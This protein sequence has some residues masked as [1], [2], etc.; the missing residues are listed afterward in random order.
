MD[1]G[2]WA[3]SL[4]GGSKFGYTLLSV[5]IISNFMAIFLQHLALKLGIATGRRSRA[6][7][8]RSHYSRPVNFMLWVACEIAIA[9]CDLAEVIGSAIALNL[10]FGIPLFYGV[11]LTALD[12]MMI[13]FLQTRGFRWIEAFVLALIAII[14]GCF[15]RG[16][17]DV[18]TRLE[19]CRGGRH[20]FARHRS[21]SGNAL[22]RHRYSRGDGDAAQSLPPL[23]DC[24]DAPL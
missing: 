16:D 18:A 23:L 14:G 10:L 13:L 24:P 22:H 11:C 7:P 19:P 12:V 17:F 5:I 1:P 20:P 6:W 15:I 21:Q 8:C 2:N 4:A 9:A 3:T